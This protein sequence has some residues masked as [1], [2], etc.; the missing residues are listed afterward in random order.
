MLGN[1]TRAGKL[2]LGEGHI[3]AGSAED[4]VFHKV[5]GMDAGVECVVDK[6]VKAGLLAA[7]AALGAVLQKVAARDRE[8]GRYSEQNGHSAVSIS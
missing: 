6:V 7:F 4:K 3:L 2:V 8:L 1:A 5:L